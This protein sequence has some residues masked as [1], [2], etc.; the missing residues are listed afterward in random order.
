MGKTLDKTVYVF[1]LIFVFGLAACSTNKESKPMETPQ[2][3]KAPPAKS[4]PD[5]RKTQVTTSLNS[6]KRGETPVTPPGQH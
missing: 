2:A 5:V 1:L 4:N 3:V 6:L